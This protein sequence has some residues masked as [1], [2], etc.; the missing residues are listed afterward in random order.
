MLLALALLSL[1]TAEP[2]AAQE[3]TAA[4]QIAAALEIAAAKNQRVLLMWGGEW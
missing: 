4:P 3:P 2:A 1:Q